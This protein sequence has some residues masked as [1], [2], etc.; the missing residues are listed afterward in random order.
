MCLGQHK[1]GEVIAIFKFRRSVGPLSKP[2]SRAARD[3]TYHALYLFLCLSEIRN[4]VPFLQRYRR[5]T[6]M[7]RRGSSTPDSFINSNENKNKIDV[8]VQI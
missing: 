6:R 1:T 7:Y 3:C 2:E 8:S 5:E 4:R